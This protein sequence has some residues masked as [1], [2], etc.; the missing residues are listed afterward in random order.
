MCSIIVAHF[1]GP[2][3]WDLHTLYNF[4]VIY[5]A[6]QNVLKEIFILQAYQFMFDTFEDCSLRVLE[7]DSRFFFTLFFK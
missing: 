4:G 5:E 6:K 2:T 3:R 7:K 1:V